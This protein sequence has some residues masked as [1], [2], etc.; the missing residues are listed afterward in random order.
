MGG[1]CAIHGHPR[2]HTAIVILALNYRTSSKPNMRFNAASAIFTMCG[3]MTSDL[4]NVV[5]GPSAGEAT[6]SMFPI[7]SVCVRQL[8]IS[9][10]SISDPTLSVRTLASATF[11]YDYTPNCCGSSTSCNLGTISISLTAL[12][13][14]GNADS[15]ELVTHGS[16]FEAGFD[17]SLHCDSGGIICWSGTPTNGGNS[18]NVCIHYANDQIC[19]DAD[20]SN[21][22]CSSVH[23]GANLP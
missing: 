8:S 14:T 13:Q 16:P 3:L 2:L 12:A 23:I 17:G 6:G 20:V 21:S 18:A 15:A 11:D 7:C 9:F 22:G 4:D 5:A 19:K 10:G 1:Y